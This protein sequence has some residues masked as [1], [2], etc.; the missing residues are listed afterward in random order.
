MSAKVQLYQKKISQ[1]KKLIIAKLL[2]GI[3]DFLMFK[4][5]HQDFIKVLRAGSHTDREGSKPARHKFDSHRNFAVEK[6]CV[7][8]K[9][10]V[11]NETGADSKVSY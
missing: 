6:R 11:L 4:N 9:Q 7:S 2:V 1:M 8:I 5:L 3:Y 10:G